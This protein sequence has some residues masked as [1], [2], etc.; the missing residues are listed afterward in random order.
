MAH[1]FTLE[2]GR[3]ILRPL[4][5][6]DAEAVFAWGSD[7]EVNRYMGY[8]PYS[9]VEQARAWLRELEEARDCVIFA[10]VLRSD[11]LVM[12]SGGGSPNGE[13]DGWK[14]GYNL[15]QDCWGQ[16]YATEALKA[17]LDFARR[18]LG[19]RVFTANHAVENPASGRVME[20]C[21]MVFERFGE[22][23]KADGSETFPAKFYRLELE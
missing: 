10:Y 11:G 7:P 1:Q 3:L 16:G 5:A 22:Y 13:G 8:L 19:I 23:K 12:G 20:K 18:E 15:R 21:G 17:I 4:T 6:E 14:V 2:T 9:D